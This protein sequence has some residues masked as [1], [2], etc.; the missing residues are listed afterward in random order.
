MKRRFGADSDD[1]GT[2]DVLEGSEQWWRQNKA[3]GGLGSLARS[4]GME[5]G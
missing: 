2:N 4:C 1:K 5:F 3:G